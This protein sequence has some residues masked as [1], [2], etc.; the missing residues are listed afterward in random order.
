VSASLP[1]SLELTPARCSG[2]A[3]LSSRTRSRCEARQ[4][5]AAGWQPWTLGW[6]E[7]HTVAIEYR[8]GEGRRF[9]RAVCTPTKAPGDRPAKTVQ[10][11]SPDPPTRVVF[12]LWKVIVT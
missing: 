1:N 9:E 4:T 11:Y 5:V 6:S 2:S 8:W 3:A 12:P 10:P 7:G